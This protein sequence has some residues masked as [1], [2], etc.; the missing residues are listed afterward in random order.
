VVLSVGAFWVSIDT[1]SG[2]AASA[3]GE[4]VPRPAR[5]GITRTVLSLMRKYGVE[6][7]DPLAVRDLL[8]G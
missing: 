8:F 3:G 7:D 4:T 6:P 5:D 2:H 1:R